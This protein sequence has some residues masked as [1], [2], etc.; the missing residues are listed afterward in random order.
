LRPEIGLIISYSNF[1]ETVELFLVSKSA[2]FDPKVV[3]IVLN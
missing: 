3:G 2:C 1:F